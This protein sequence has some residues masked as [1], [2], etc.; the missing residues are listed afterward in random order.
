MREREKRVTVEAT[1]HE[2]EEREGGASGEKKGVIVSGK[3]EKGRK[4]RVTKLQITSG[5]TRFPLPGQI[6]SPISRKSCRVWQKR[7]QYSR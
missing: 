5:S 2:K 7:N 4:S 1:E 6:N 3:E